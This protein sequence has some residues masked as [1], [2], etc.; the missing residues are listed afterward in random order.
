MDE[1]TRV[2]PAGFALSP[3]QLRAFEDER[4][5]PM[6]TRA[7][8]VAIVS[9]LIW[10]SHF[11]MYESDIFPTRTHSLAYRFAQFAACAGIVV[12][13]RKP[14][15]L[16]A[17][18]SASLFTWCFLVLAH[19]GAILV[20]YP[21]CVMP[22]TLTLEWGQMVIALASLLSWRSTVALFTWTWV[23]GAAVTIVRANWDV[24]LSDHVVLAIIYAVVAASVRAFDRLR[25]DEFVGRFRLGAANE[26]L[27]K[28]ED[29]R[30]RLFTNLSHDFRTPLALIRGETERLAG[31]LTAPASR[32]ALARV[33]SQA[34]ALADL[35]DQLLE[36]ARFDAGRTP[37]A[38]RDFD[39][40]ALASEL[41]A[42]FSNAASGTTIVVEDATRS[43]SA[44][45][46]EGVGVRADPSHVRR[47]LTNLLDNAVRQV[48]PTGGDVRV[49]IDRFGER[50]S[51]EVRDT[52][53]GIAPARRAQIFERFASFDAAG[54]VASGIGLPLARELA[55]LNGGRLVLVDDAPATTF[56][57]ELPRGEPE[58][59]TEAMHANQA[60][61]LV[62]AD[63]PSLARVRTPRARESLLLLEDHV[64][65]QRLLGSLLEDHFAVRC[66]GCLR[67]AREALRAEPPQIIVSDIMLPDGDGYDL[68]R[69]VHGRRD[70]EAVP[71]IFVS[72]LAEA[73]QRTAGMRAGADDYITKPFSA[74][75]LVARI[76]TAA[77]RARSR[78]VALDVQRQQFVAEIHDG[79]GGALGRAGV[80]LAAAEAE[81]TRTELIKQAREAV[82]EAIDEARGLMKVAE[83]AAEPWDL[84]TRMLRGDVETLTAGFH[85]AT[86]FA[87]ATD[88]TCPLVAPFELHV[89]RRVVRECVTNTIKHASAR[90]LVVRIEGRRG[91]VLMRVDDDGTGRTG[92]LETGSGRGLKIV[93]RRIV[94]LGGAIHLSVRPLGGT[95]IETVCPL[96]FGVRIQA[97]PEAA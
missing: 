22:F 15:P 47:I 5:K 54:S 59:L 28:I 79:V 31:S 64:E 78:R 65:M 97:E 50:I 27:R 51:I 80:L 8:Y 86:Q 19:G 88:G 71:F 2:V 58:P 49:R 73:T 61:V 35:T 57:V 44:A 63:E 36:L 48:H 56:R 85:V 9:G 45:A 46:H 40:T 21:S 1:T 24:D 68:L 92:T 93:E 91:E 75:E 33:Q 83:G 4:A 30:T 72:A 6:R 84:A 32:A 25:V 7:R 41:V 96:Q 89:L 74:A 81:P 94:D 10:L 77:A 14:R 82:R 69:E 76:R 60:S 67:Q 16:R 66:A 26:A 34:A 53:P 17:V 3:E 43:A 39:V 18:E 12:Y 29:A 95:S 90:E 52:G 13:L 55:E 23:V 87:C 42:H 11:L 20:V 70:M 38:P 62:D 37:T